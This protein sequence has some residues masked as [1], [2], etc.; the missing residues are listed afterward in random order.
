MIDLGTAAGQPLSTGYGINSRG[1]VVGD[2]NDNGWLWEDGSIVDLNTL[3]PT[4]SNVH[5]G[6]AIAINDRGEIV[7]WGL[8]SDGSN[9]VVVLI[10]CD[11]DHAGV[12]GCDY[13]LVEGDSAA[14]AGL[15]PASQNSPTANE[16]SPTTGGMRST[17]FRRFAGPLGH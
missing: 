9:H 4:N 15:A 10:P 8:P 11:D 3:V 13:S 17:R 14:G 5:V 1:Q 2:S 7:A 16:N 12:E 6:K